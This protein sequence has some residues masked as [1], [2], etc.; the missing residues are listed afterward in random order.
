MRVGGSDEMRRRVKYA[1]T[2]DP[3]LFACAFADGPQAC[4]GFGSSGIPGESSNGSGGEP[5]SAPFLLLLKP[6][7]EQFALL[8]TSELAGLDSAGFEA[9]LTNF[10]EANWQPKPSSAGS[11]IQ[12]ASSAQSS[13]AAARSAAA[14]R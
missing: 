7:D 4:A 9:R 3:S 13:A 2:F 14:R 8:P 10:V 12:A 6:F 5:P 11:R 1:H